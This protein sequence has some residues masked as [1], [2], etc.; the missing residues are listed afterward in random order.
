MRTSI[1]ATTGTLKRIKNNNNN[2]KTRTFQT[3]SDT[4]LAVKCQWELLVVSQCKKQ[5]GVNYTCA[6]ETKTLDVSC[7]TLSKKKDV[8]L[9]KHRNVLLRTAHSV[10]P[11]NNAEI[12]N[13]SNYHM[14]VHAVSTLPPL[15]GVPHVCCPLLKLSFIPKYLSFKEF[16]SVNIF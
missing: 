4:D 12:R 1:M 16:C 9:P 3:L 10:T 2:Q 6:T 15:K 14:H 5:P 11:L 7:F 13:H 8:Q